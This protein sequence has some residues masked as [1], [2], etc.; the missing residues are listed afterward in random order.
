VQSG[1]IPSTDLFTFTRAGLTWIN[2][3]WLTQVAFYGLYT[4][5]GL[6]LIIF[7]HALT[8]TLGY[9]LV[10]LACLRRVGDTRA[11]VVVRVAAMSLGITNWNVRPQ[12]VS[13]LLFGLG[14]EPQIC[15]ESHEF[16]RNKMIS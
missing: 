12:S 10:G 4:V 1:A 7:V 5:G 13:V 16:T 14:G 11:A 15:H 8:I 9:L 3:S 6:P 2:Q